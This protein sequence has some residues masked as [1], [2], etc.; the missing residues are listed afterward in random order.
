M[1]TF[2]YL[3][4]HR[5]ERS[6]GYEDAVR[7]FHARLWA[8]LPTLRGSASYHVRGLPWLDGTEGYEDWY[9]LPGFGELA[10]LNEAAVSDAVREAHDRAALASAWGAGGLYATIHGEPDLDA[11]V[12][13]WLTKPRDVSYP[14]FFASLPPTPCLLRRQLVLGPAPEFCAFG[15]VP[16]GL[17]EERRAVTSA[18]EAPAAPPD[19]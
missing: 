13:T 17:V 16:G 11:R 2:A 1:T 9:L 18:A 19:R 14:E 6:D 12:V 8:A 10:A 3:F 4:W 5:P 15:E 7:V